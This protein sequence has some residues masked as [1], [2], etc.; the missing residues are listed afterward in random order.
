LNKAAHAIGEATMASGRAIAFAGRVAAHGVAHGAKAIG[1]FIAKGAAW[2]G[3]R[4]S[5]LR[6]F[7]RV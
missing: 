7:E 3:N 4:L 1:T 2:I 6:G 5:G